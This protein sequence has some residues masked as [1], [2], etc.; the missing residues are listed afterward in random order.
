MRLVA[1]PDLGSVERLT[2]QD[3]G[4]EG[5]GSRDAVSASTPRPLVQGYLS[6]RET[7]TR[8]TLQ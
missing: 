7:P 1:L 4:V 5:S 3:S 6:Y 2:V 8:K